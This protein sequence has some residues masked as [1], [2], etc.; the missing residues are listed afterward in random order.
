MQ[1]HL[2]STLRQGPFHTALRAAIKARGLSLDRLRQRLLAA[3][4][5][6]GLA[7]L[8]AWQSGRRRPE[9]PESM[10]AVTV[11]ERVLELPPRSLFRLLGAPR[12]RGPGPRR[13]TPPRRFAEIIQLGEPVTALTEELGWRDDRLRVISAWDQVRV[14]AGSCLTSMESLV[15]LEAAADVDRYVTVHH[16]APGIDLGR[17]VRFEAL[18]HCRLGRVRQHPQHPLIVAELLLDRRLRAGDTA[19]VRFRVTDTSGSPDTEFG[20]FFRA[21]AQHTALALTFAPDA[22]PARC[23]RFTRERQ[24]WPDRTRTEVPVGPY[25]D[26]HVVRAPVPPGFVGIGWEPAAV[27]DGDANGAAGEPPTAPVDRVSA[28]PAPATRR[29]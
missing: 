22:R 15:T 23:W 13:R 25:G 18:A 3:G 8:S 9:R 21:P 6:V 4:T 27:P 29:W 12:P 5:P 16:G 28:P 26:V 2:R 17:T 10:S 20:R 7:T 11:L 19:L 1:Q 24:G 14:S